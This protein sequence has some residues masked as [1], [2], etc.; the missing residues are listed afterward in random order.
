MRAYMCMSPNNVTC[1]F[2]DLLLDDEVRVTADVIAPFVGRLVRLRHSAL[3]CKIVKEFKH[4][5]VR[6]GMA[7]HSMPH[8]R[9][10]FSEVLSKYEI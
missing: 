4:E 10:L 7:A 2:T 3:V 6:R 1:A 9:A 5:L 8:K